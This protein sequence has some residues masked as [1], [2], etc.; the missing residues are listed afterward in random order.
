MAPA[1]EGQP[2]QQVTGL[3]TLLELIVER[4]QKAPDELLAAGDQMAE[5]LKRELGKAAVAPQPLEK[6]VV[7]SA[8]SAL[9][10]QFDDAVRRLWLQCVQSAAAKVSLSRRT[11]SSCS[12]VPGGRLTATN[13]G[14]S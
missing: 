4:W 1:K 11:C 5:Y 3:L 9:A 8:A 6:D 13:S 10:D 2:A 14:C 7:D 12:S